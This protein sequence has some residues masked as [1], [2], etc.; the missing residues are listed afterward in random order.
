MGEKKTTEDVPVPE[1]AAPTDPRA[2]TYTVQF[3]RRDLV[4]EGNEISSPTT[5]IEA[6][7]D[8]A[9]VT[10]PARARRRKV[11]GLALAQSGLRPEVGGDPLRLR[12]LDAASA[13]ETSVSAVQAEPTLEF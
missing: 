13:H 11:I 10:V 3:L 9:T 5:E 2:A 4:F 7:I 8:I 12:V 6:W 1:V